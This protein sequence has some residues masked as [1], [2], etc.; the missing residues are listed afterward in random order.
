ML[1]EEIAIWDS[2]GTTQP[3]MVLSLDDVPITIVYQRP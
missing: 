2:F 1:S 3:A